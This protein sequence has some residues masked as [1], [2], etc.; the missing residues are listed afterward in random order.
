[1]AWHFET[2]LIFLTY[3]GGRPTYNLHRY[4][5]GCFS[6]IAEYFVK[7]ATFKTINYSEKLERTAFE[8]GDRSVWKTCKFAV[9]N[10]NKFV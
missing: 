10:S 1:M 2:I 5:P 3:R 8:N 7:P 6:C 4:I 9:F